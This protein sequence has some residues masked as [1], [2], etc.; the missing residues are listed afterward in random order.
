M[1]EEIDLSKNLYDMGT[2]TGRAAH[3]Y[4]SVNPLNLVKDTA[5][6]KE[7]VDKIKANGGVL[8]GL[9]FK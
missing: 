3:F 7:I 8:P 6:A 1:G 5:G 9:K 4:R 2:Y